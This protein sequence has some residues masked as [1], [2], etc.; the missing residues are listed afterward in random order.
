MFAAS[1]MAKAGGSMAMTERHDI[2]SIYARVSPFM[3]VPEHRDGS[4]A[5]RRRR[6]A[7]AMTTTE[8]GDTFLVA[9]NASP[10][11]SMRTWELAI[12]SITVWRSTRPAV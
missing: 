9:W 10:I 7:T 6:A 8:T 3:Q 1:G 11:T 5:R 2:A 4:P 12:R